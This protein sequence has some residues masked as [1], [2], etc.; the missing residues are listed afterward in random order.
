M[1]QS[2]LAVL[3]LVLLAAAYS[4]AQ[5]VYPPEDPSHPPH[6]KILIGVSLS[7]NASTTRGSQSRQF[8]R[9]VTLAFEWYSQQP[10]FYFSDGKQYRIYL[11]VYENFDNKTLMVEQ[12]QTMVADPSI[13]FLLGPLNSMFCHFFI[14]FFT[15]S[16]YIFIFI[17]LTSFFYLNNKI[18][19]RTVSFGVLKT[20][21]ELIF[22]PYKKIKKSNFQ[23]W[24]KKQPK[25]LI[26]PI[27]SDD[28]IKR[29]KKKSTQRLLVRG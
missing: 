10:N 17:L 9:G 6:T 15:L 16:F 28:Q 24:S 18:I 13:P 3:L 19:T 4:Q 23:S 20:R 7:Q 26:L 29:I 14:H 12:Y 1:I 25:T 11:A 22:P 2:T 21:V 27:S 8:W 5:L